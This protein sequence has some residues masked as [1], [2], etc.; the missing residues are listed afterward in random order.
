VTGIPSI[1]LDCDVLGYPDFTGMAPTYVLRTSPRKYQCY[2]EFDELQTDLAAVRT[3]QNAMIKR[4]GADEAAKALSQMFRLPLSLHQR[5]GTVARLMSGLGIGRKYSF[6]ELKRE[7]RTR[8][9]IIEP[10]RRRMPR[11]EAIHPRGLDQHVLN[12]YVADVHVWGKSANVA[13]FKWSAFYAKRT[14]LDDLATADTL[15][16]LFL[17]GLNLLERIDVAVDL[18]RQIEN[19]IK[20]GRN[21]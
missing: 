1:V 11:E 7:A 17:I 12:K 3:L 20:A 8:G 6:G 21:S 13:L 18:R 9:V 5:H 10:P 19:G 16:R 14:E 4:Y 15:E 2:F